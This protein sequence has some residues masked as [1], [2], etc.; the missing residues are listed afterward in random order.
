MDG[1]RVIGLGNSDCCSIAMRRVASG[2]ITRMNALLFRSRV[3]TNSEREM[4]EE[5]YIENALTL[6]SGFRLSAG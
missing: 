5:W 2:R 4:L 3:D 1:I 6:L